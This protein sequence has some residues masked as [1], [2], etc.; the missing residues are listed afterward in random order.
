MLNEVDPDIEAFAI[1]GSPTIE[2]YTFLERFS[3]L[4]YVYLWW[5]NKAASLWDITKTPDIEFLH[6][7]EINNLSDISQLK[8]AQRLRYLKM[9]GG[10]A[11][12]VGLAP[13]ENLPE[14]EFVSL[15]RVTDDADL[16]TLIALPN[17]RYFDCQFNIFDIDAYAMFEVKRPD[18]DTN[19]W[20][21]IEGYE[22]ERP[23]N[24]CFVGLVG[25]RQGLAKS[26][27]SDK[28][29]KHRQKFLS[30]KRK[31]LTSDL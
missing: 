26:D 22:Y 9:L 4:K 27:D 23:V 24:N 7:E 28:Q 18:V 11:S 13:I 25:K 12:I 15:Y 31:Y 21:G 6:L 1:T 17:L 19:F 14:L 20:E 29:E 10:K 16:Q 8:N 2:D 3:A 5:N 30:V